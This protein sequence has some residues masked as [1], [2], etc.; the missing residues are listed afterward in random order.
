MNFLREESTQPGSAILAS[1]S[2][3]TNEQWRMLLLECA[4]LLGS[5]PSQFY[6]R[7]VV[8]LFVLLQLYKPQLS[9][10]SDSCLLKVQH[11]TD[12]WM[13]LLASSLLGKF[14]SSQQSVLI[15]TQPSS[16]IPPVHHILCGVMVATDSFKLLRSCSSTCKKV[17][18]GLEQLIMCSSGF[19]STWLQTM[20]FYFES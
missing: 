11:W 9:L 4:T 18:K 7:I 13:H 6:T 5:I 1:F 17:L 2:V 12:T 8:G 15:Q 16:S 10:D 3:L 14:K 20:K 19:T